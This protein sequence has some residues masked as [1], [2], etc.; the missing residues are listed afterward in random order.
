M[1]TSLL[2]MLALRRALG[3]KERKRANRHPHGPVGV[4]GGQKVRQVGWGGAWTVTAQ[5]HMALPRSQ[6]S[7]PRGSPISRSCAHVPRRR[8]KTPPVLSMEQSLRRVRAESR[9]FSLLL[10]GGSQDWACL[11]CPWPKAV[12][13]M[14]RGSRPT[15]E[16]SSSALGRRAPILQ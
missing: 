11:R 3:K 1:K 5:Q 12:P 14:Q 7:L 13:G 8:A 16:E 9:D 15:L 4:R 6:N 2:G 10:F